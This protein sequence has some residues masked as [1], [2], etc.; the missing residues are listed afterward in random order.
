MKTTVGRTTLNVIDANRD[1][2]SAFIS[3]VLSKPKHTFKLKGTVDVNLTITLPSPPEMPGAV[4]PFGKFADAAKQI[5]KLAPSKTIT[6]TGIWFETD[7]TLDGF[8]NFPEIE[9][10]ELLEKI[11]NADGSFTIKS[12]VNI[13]NVSQFSVKMGDV[14]FKTIDAMSPEPFGDTVFEQLTLARKDNFVTAV[15]T[16]TSATKNPHEI[17][18]RV[19]ENG[20]TFR[21]VGSLESSKD[22]AVL[23]KGISVVDT[24]VN[25]PVLNKPV[26]AAGT[27]PADGAAPPSD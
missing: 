12:K 7:V 17:Y 5:S 13:K 21:F 10:V 11:E 27:A 16:S 14:Q 23:A 1:K 26:P 2:F 15:T 22:D 9:F 4:G 6:I 18:T 3:S 8:A 25:I 19:T 24:K 20:E